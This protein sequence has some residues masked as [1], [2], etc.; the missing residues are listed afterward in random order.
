[1]KKNIAVKVEN[2]SKHY[3]IYERARDRVKEA[4]N[5]FR[6]KYYSNFCAI[7]NLSFEIQKGEVLGLFGLNGAG[8]STLLKMIAGVLTPSS[9]R[10]N[11][12]G[13]INAMIE[14]G[15]SLNP[16]LTGR[17]N[18][19]FNLDLNNIPSEDREKVTQEI[20]DFAEIGLY[21]DQPV[22][23][24]SSGMGARLGFGIATAVKPEILII[25]EVLAVGDA[26]F[27]NKCF[28]KI[29]QLLKGGT[30][31]IFVSH[32]V[33]LMIEFCSRAI[34]L[35]KRQILLDGHPKEVAHYY[36]K[37]LFS[38]DKESV[39]KEIRALNKDDAE[40]DCKEEIKLDSVD[41]SNNE[42]RKY[43]MDLITGR[44]GIY[45]LDGNLTSF[46]ETGMEYVLSLDVTFKKSFKK[47]R[48][49]FASQEVTG[50]VLPTFDSYSENNTIENVKC[51][52][53]YSISTQFKCD[54]FKG[55][56][57]AYVTFFDV[58]DDRFDDQLKATQIGIRFEA[59]TVSKEN[60]IKIQKI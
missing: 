12:H 22:K 50:K 54:V 51:S 8:K 9:G 3:K 32:N 21:I 34:F 49:D 44:K 25:D 39:I 23:N 7:D 41:I 47:V 59:G 36:Q 55:N 52:E 11:V 27:Q 53:K 43:E 33:S 16:E 18:I 30:T 26:I 4:F 20:I 56:Y 38:E 31:V 14:I 13:R 17:Q 19:K 46:L 2:V 6:K 1:M 35:H 45:D 57:T 58:S 37:A 29:R 48:V 24:Y 10:I 5:P 60:T 40:T 28:V 15:S 42:S